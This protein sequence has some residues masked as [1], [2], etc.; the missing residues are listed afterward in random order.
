MT[1]HNKPIQHAAAWRGAEV[2]AC[3][4]W[5]LEWTNQDVAKLQKWA[6]EQEAKF[7]DLP[8]MEALQ[9]DPPVQAVATI[10]E[11]IRFAQDRLEHGAGVVRIQGFPAEAFDE[12]TTKLMFWQICRQLGTPVSQSALGERLFDV[13]DAGFANDDQRARGPNTRK[14]LSFHTDRCDVIGF[15]CYRQAKQGGD[16]LIVS[17]I[18]LFNT[19]LEERPDLVD[20]LMQPYLYQRHNV[21]VGN[22]K[23][24]IE[25]PIFSIHQGHFAAN[26]LR[27]LIERAYAAPDTPAM[28]DLQR[29]ALDY[30]EDLA[31]QPRM[32][33]CF[34]QSAGDMLFLN[35]FVTLHRR[36]EFEDHE[37]PDRRRHLF[38]IWLS[39]PNSRPLAP[40]F[41]GNYGDTAAGA[42]RGGMA[43]SEGRNLES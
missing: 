43:K 26:L 21:D 35:N 29:E 14:K 8:W 15:L 28:S 18:S 27:V 42:I 6:N 5:N 2:E 11:K 32:H 38:R 13:R 12:R 17:S 19:M 16:N 30:L 36:T 24:Y 41:A 33:F 34:R 7:A 22:E 1:L 10:A 39:M 40:A 9:N 31:S 37:Q 25:Q 3:P 4:E 23:S 20:V